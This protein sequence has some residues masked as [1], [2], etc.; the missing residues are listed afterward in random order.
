MRAKS[1]VTLAAL[2][3]PF[4]SVLPKPLRPSRRQEAIRMPQRFNDEVAAYARFFFFRVRTTAGSTWHDRDRRC[5][6]AFR[7]V[8]SAF[9][10]LFPADAEV[11]RATL[12]FLVARATSLRTTEKDAANA[13]R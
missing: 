8:W 2:F 13:A 6:S 11:E 5:C 4:S 12:F 3:C 1:T 7:P 10:G 9:G